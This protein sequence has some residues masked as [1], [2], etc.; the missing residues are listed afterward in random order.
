MTTAVSCSWCHT[1]NVLTPGTPVTC[2]ACSHRGDVCRLDCDCGRMGCLP[3]GTT[4]PLPVRPVPVRLP[5]WDDEDDDDTPLH[6][7]GGEGG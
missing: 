1:M 5:E 7:M 3:T 2:Y 4:P 6:D